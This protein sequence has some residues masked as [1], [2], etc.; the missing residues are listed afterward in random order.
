MFLNCA[1]L[2]SRHPFLNLSLKSG[3]SLLPDAFSYLLEAEARIQ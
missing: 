3:S 2:V 1:G